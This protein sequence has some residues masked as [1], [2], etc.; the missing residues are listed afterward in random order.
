[1]AS[2][3]GNAGSAC[4]AG[5]MAVLQGLGYPG[6]NRSHFKSIAIWDTAWFMIECLRI[7]LAW[8]KISFQSLDLM[9]WSV[10][11]EADGVV[12]VEQHALCNARYSCQHRRRD[13]VWQ[14]NGSHQAWS[15]ERGYI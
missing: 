4:Q 13:A 12:H 11:C 3:L 1:M 14:R 6:Q 5:G 8:T 7:G 10:Y 9:G 2:Y 15:V